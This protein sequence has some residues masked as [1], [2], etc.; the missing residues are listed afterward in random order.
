MRSLSTS[1]VALAILGSVPANAADIVGSIPICQLTPQQAA[2][3]GAVCVMPLR[4]PVAFLDQ[5]KGEVLKT[6]TV[7]YTPL[8]GG[9]SPS[10]L[11][12]GDRVLFSGNAQAVLIAGNCQKAI[13]PNST[14]VIRQLDANCAYAALTGQQSAPSALPFVI[15][16]GTI[17]T[18]VI[19]INQH[20]P[21]ASP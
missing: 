6:A 4:Q 21:P 20:P 19:L 8:P 5:I 14:L 7:G 10:I 3:L 15:L 16:A 12:V 17:L 9:S 1:V 18:T 13:G 2:D 11:V